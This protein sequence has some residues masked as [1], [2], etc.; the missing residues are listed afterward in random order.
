M[1]Y[2]HIGLQV[3]KILL[4]KKGVD[5]QRWA[6]IACDQ[7]TSDRD[8]WRHL[9][10]QV[11]LA[12]STLRLTLPE[13]YL[14]DSDV[15]ERIQ[16]IN[17]TMETYLTQGVLEEQPPGLVL[18]DRRTSAVPSRKGLMVALDLE[19]YDYRPGSQ[20]LIRAT[21]GTIIERLPPRVRV[22]ENA[23]IELPHI[24]VLIDDPQHTVIEPLFEEK[25]EQVYDV[26]L[27]CK[28]GHLKGYR[29]DQPE[30]LDQVA[31]A[32]EKLAD[33]QSYRN[34]YNVE[35]EVM[36]YAMGDGNHSFATAKAIWEK[37]KEEAGD[38]Q[39]VMDHPA[40]F[41]LVELVNVHDPGL[42]FEAIHRMLFDVDGDSLKQQMDEFFARRGTS[43]TM[44]PCRDLK[45]AKACLDEIQGE[46]TF[47]MVVAGDYFACD[48]ADP[49][50]T[51]EVASL[52]AFL[53]N[54]LNR[55]AEVRI[56]YI[57][58]EYE[59]TSL[60]SKEK[61]AGFYLPAISKHDLFRTIVLDGAL[62]RKTFSMGEA[63][64]KRFYLE[65]RRIKDDKV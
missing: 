29:V 65:C 32:L 5:M 25:L 57:H 19:R 14:E 28:G 12:P 38:P 45:D 9:D 27:L 22:R 7:Y 2:E 47:V 34:R 16:A 42:E 6:V 21:E 24:M 13:V 4:P 20:S 58:G 51:L 26:E 46:H 50:F 53:D 18:V 37:L 11:G 56:D 54:F 63:D 15:E 64:E 3:P 8:Y 17:R 59:V 10:E 55:N 40:R 62:P 39:Q 1:I 35:G 31:N 49:E 48:I 36:L 44:T 30:L 23:P 33:P 52:Q 43:L 61:C 60:G 41:A